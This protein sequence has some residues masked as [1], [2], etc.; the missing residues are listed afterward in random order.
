L[1]SREIPSKPLET[2]IGGRGL[3]T[4][5]DAR[6]VVPVD[7]QPVVLP[8][9]GPVGAS[10]LPDVLDPDVVT[11]GEVSLLNNRF[12]AQISTRP[13]QV[14]ASSVLFH[15]CVV[16]LILLQPKLF[17][18]TPRAQAELNLARQQLAFIY[19]P[20]SVRDVPKL[21]PPRN[22]PS[23]PQIRIDPR[24]LR[25]LAPPTFEPLPG[26]PERESPPVLRDLPSA[27]TPQLPPTGGQEPGRRGES[28]RETAL[29]E[30]PKSP[31]APGHL[32]LPQLSPGKAL[33]ESVRGAAKGQGGDAGG[34]REPAPPPAGG[35]GGQGYLGGNVELLT[36]T[37]GV[38]FTNYLAR[39][40]ASVKRNW[41]AVIPESARLGEK[42]RVVLQF[43]ILRD[44]NVPYAEPALISTSGREP[45]DRA[46]ISAIRASSPFEPLPPAFSGPFIELRFIFLYNL[47]LEYR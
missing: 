46:A 23:S 14:K 27:P 41:Y 47:P 45:L 25:E 12:E 31:E 8:T 43:H 13:W 29:L 35:G 39:V 2:N 17:P 20:P 7:A 9:R 42:G 21:P 36:P 44:G 18:Y 4:P 40:L 34:F 22:E 32:L 28:P 24:V 3:E 10:E 5:L 11:T 19:L 38:D 37:E 30:T 26:P 6:V 15:A 16:A 1:V 33:E